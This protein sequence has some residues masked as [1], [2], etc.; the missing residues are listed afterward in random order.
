MKIPTSGNTGRKWGTQIEIWHSR[1]NLS[2]TGFAYEA[3]LRSD[4]CGSI[5]FWVRGSCL[6]ATC[7][8]WRRTGSRGCE[9]EPQTGESTEEVC[10]GAEE[11]GEENAEDGAQEQLQLSDPLELSST[12]R[13][14][15]LS[16]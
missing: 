13:S 16:S 15:M 10:E 7:S 5:G 8:E 11:G 4:L 12:H 1:Y 2:K 6:L 14:T 3:S 9:S